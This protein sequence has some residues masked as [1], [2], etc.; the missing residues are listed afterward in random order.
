V[1]IYPNPFLTSAFVQLP[2]D[3]VNEEKN[4]E[5]S[6]YDIIGKK[7]ISFPVLSDKVKINRENLEGGMYLFTL[8]QKFSGKIFSSGKIIIL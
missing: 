6:I 7:L 2:I 5:F 4:L 8:E 1:K 3:I